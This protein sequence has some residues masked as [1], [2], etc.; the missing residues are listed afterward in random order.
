MQKSSTS[1]QVLSLNK[2]EGESAQK[3]STLDQP[4]L[5]SFPYNMPGK[6]QLSSMKFNIY[7]ENK[8]AGSR[9]RKRVLKSAHKA[10]KYEA[11]S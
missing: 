1:F 9:L 3:G 8:P 10:I 5:V 2:E 6:Q 7:E 4:V 11:S